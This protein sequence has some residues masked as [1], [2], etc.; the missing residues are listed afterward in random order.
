[1]TAYSSP[2]ADDIT[3]TGYH[4]PTL[5]SAIPSYAF[6]HDHHLHHFD[7][8]TDYGRY[9]PD[10]THLPGMMTDGT[11]SK[12]SDMSGGSGGD[13]GG[14]AAAAAMSSTYR[15]IGRNRRRRANKRQPFE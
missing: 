11:V 4:D 13:G 3:Y 8:A 6:D 12:D 10:H 14:G 2:Y 9:L 1:M 5:H 15:R 7:H